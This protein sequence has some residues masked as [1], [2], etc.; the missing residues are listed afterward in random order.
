MKTLEICYSETSYTL[1]GIPYL[2]QAGQNR[3]IN[4]ALRFVIE[5]CEPYFR[6]DKNITFNNYEP[7]SCGIAVSKWCNYGWNLRKNM[8]FLII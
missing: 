2:G 8:I 6:T 3:I 5:L 4:L 7:R 1:V